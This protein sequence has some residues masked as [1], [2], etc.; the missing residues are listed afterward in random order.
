MAGVLLGGICSAS[1]TGA[2]QGGPLVV[3]EMAADESWMILEQTGTSNVYLLLDGADRNNGAGIANPDA[4]GVPEFI[5]FQN[6]AMRDRQ[7]DALVQDLQD[8]FTKEVQRILESANAKADDPRLD[9]DLRKRAQRQATDAFVHHS[10]GIP[11]WQG[12]LIDLAHAK[13]WNIGFG[14]DQGKVRNLV[15]N[16][17]IGPL[18]MDWATVLGAVF[19]ATKSLYVT[20]GQVPTVYRIAKEDWSNS[21]RYISKTGSEQDLNAVAVVEVLAR[22]K[23]AIGFQHFLDPQK[24]PELRQY[25]KSIDRPN[26]FES[27]LLAALDRPSG[28]AVQAGELSR[29]DLLQF[30]NRYERVMLRARRRARRGGGDFAV[31]A[32]HGSLQVAIRLEKALGAPITKYPQA[33]VP[34]YWTSLGDK[35]IGQT[36]TEAR[37]LGGL[38][39]PDIQRVAVFGTGVAAKLIVQGV[40]E[41]YGRNVQIVWFPDVPSEAEQRRRAWRH[42]AQAILGV[43]PRN[44]GI[45]IEIEDEPD[46]CPQ[47]DDDCTDV[48]DSLA[49]PPLCIGPGCN[50]GRR[51]VRTDDGPGPGGGGGG[52]PPG[53]PGGG[54]DGFQPDPGIGP[55]GRANPLRTADG[56]GPEGCGGVLADPSPV[57]KAGSLDSIRSRVLGGCDF[58]KGAACDLN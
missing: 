16:S 1:D 20:G 45:D 10:A 33:N 43:R 54:G 6:D 41:R 46:A 19:L 56:C 44:A 2:Q 4:K 21:K 52:L 3:V 14:K 13:E 5:R 50:P 53:G 36:L 23:G 30:D 31:L 17:N 25:L 39:S 40:E 34:S 37:V 11:G 12:R 9:A 29:I 35:P 28:T 22:A 49:I 57:S 15:V 7:R 26:R 24:K 47:T 18:N 48:Y 42:G 55:G 27:D 51:L 8:R 58:S 32:D 38:I